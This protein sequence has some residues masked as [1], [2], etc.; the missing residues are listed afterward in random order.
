MIS[1]SVYFYEM[2]LGSLEAYLTSMKH[3][4]KYT[5][6][7]ASITCI[8]FGSKAVQISPAYSVLLPNIP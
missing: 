4:P 5:V 3:L 8:W 2:K 6:I 1:S 7:I